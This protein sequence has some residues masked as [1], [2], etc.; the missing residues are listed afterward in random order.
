MN[1]LEIKYL[2]GSD[3]KIGAER[4]DECFQY[5]FREVN[6]GVSDEELA[7]LTLSFRDKCVKEKIVSSYLDVAAIDILVG[8]AFDNTL[9][10][11]MARDSLNEAAEAYDIVSKTASEEA[12]FNLSVPLAELLLASEDVKEAQRF[13]LLAGTSAYKLKKPEAS[14]LLSLYLDLAYRFPASEYSSHVLSDDEISANFPALA[15]SLLAYKKE[16]H[17]LLHDPIETS[18]SFFAVIDDVN[19]EIYLSTPKNESWDPLRL[20]KAKKA[21]LEKHGILW[22]GPREMNP[23]L[24]QE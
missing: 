11:F 5:L 14:H 19:Q 2:I 6:R 17:G 15:K 24:P 3:R 4:L 22:K 10:L 12:K 1:D 13:Y 20:E 8:E 9:T 23:S 21:L 7:A 18:A 16:R